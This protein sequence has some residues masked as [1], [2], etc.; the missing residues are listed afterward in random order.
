MDIIY[1][2]FFKSSDKVCHF[3]LLNKI[4]VRFRSNLVTW[5]GSYLIDRLQRVHIGNFISKDIYE[6]TGVPQA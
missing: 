4:H 6:Y 2:D 5:I 1:T 3:L